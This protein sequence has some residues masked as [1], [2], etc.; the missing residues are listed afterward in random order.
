MPIDEEIFERA[1]QNAEESYR[2]V[3]SKINPRQHM[4]FFNG[5]CDGSGNSIVKEIKGN[6][7]LGR[8]LKSWC[9]KT[10]NCNIEFG[11]KATFKLKLP[12]TNDWRSQCKRPKSI[13][14]QNFLNTL[15]KEGISLRDAH[16]KVKKSE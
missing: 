13:A 11:D 8:G 14:L 3:M 4:Q 2:S 6:T 10:D 15:K 12:P 7:S 5:I 1:L 16:V 9:K